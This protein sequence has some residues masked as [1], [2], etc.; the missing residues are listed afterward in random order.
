MWRATISRKNAPCF[1]RCANEHS[2]V[3]ENFRLHRKACKPIV[4]ARACFQTVDGLELIAFLAAR[5]APFVNHADL[6]AKI[7]RVERRRLGAY[8]D[9]DV[10]HHQQV[11]ASDRFVIGNH[12]RHQAYQARIP[13]LVVADVIVEDDQVVFVPGDVTLHRWFEDRRIG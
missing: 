10:E 1:A 11:V 13:M 5:L 2:T 9:V 6:C 8:Q 4:L 3:D 7:K 12:H